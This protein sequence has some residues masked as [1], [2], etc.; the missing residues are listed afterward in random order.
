MSLSQRYYAL[1]TFRGITIALMIL[2]NSAGDG[3]TTYAILQHAPWHGFTLA[4]FVFP[5]FLFIVG[6]A[7]RFAL[8]PF[9]YQLSTEVSLKILRRTATL[10]LISYLIF[11]FPYI[12]FQLSHLRILNVLQRIALCYCAVSFL[13]LLIKSPNF[14]MGI[15]LFL[16]LGYWAIMLHFGDPSDPFGRM[17]N[18]A[19]KADLA[20]MGPDHLYHGEGYPFDPEGLLSTLPSIAT[21]LLGYLT[22][23]F[24]QNTQ[25]KSLVLSRLLLAGVGLVAIALLWNQVFPI[26]KKLW[27]SSFVVLVAGLDLLVLSLLIWLIDVQKRTGWTTFFDVFG[28]NSIFAYGLSELLAILLWFIKISS[29]SLYPTIFQQVFR[30]IFGDY[31]GSLAFAISFVLVCWLGCYLLYRKKIFLKI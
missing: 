19:L 22:G 6:V 10:F 31:N 24:I 9:Q 17:G 13:A 5:S 25:N 21:A 27:T 11:N 28:K 7:I 4:D 1:D 30:P 23:Y 20:V 3:D 15:C 2:V 26:N 16:L 18:A 29:E 12:H 8:R 14:L